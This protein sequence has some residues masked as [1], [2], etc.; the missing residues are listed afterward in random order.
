MNI[1]FLSGALF[2]SSCAKESCTEIPINYRVLSNHCI[3]QDIAKES[4]DS[5]SQYVI[6]NSQEEFDLIK[7]SS[8]EEIIDF[9]RFS[10]IVG[11]ENLTNGVANTEYDVSQGCTTDQVLKINIIITLNDA[12]VAPTVTYGIIVPKQLSPNINLSVTIS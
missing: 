2:I 9:N 6:I 12:Q 7:T 1:L 3:Q 4:I 8:C 5:E 10:L 11:Y